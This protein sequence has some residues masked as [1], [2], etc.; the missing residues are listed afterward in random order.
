[1]VGSKTITTKLTSKSLKKKNVE[2]FFDKYFFEIDSSL[3]KALRRKR[4]SL[5]K[6][7]KRNVTQRQNTCSARSLRSD[8]VRAKV[9]S[10]RSDRT[11]IP[12]G[13]YVATELEPKFRSYVVT[14]RSIATTLVHAFL[15]TLRCYLPKTV[16]N[17]F[18]D[19][20]PF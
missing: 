4:E 12:L 19:S 18:H 17:P 13:R 2:T 6:S 9:R 14:G 10:L 3:Q 8:R 7:P 11:S 20:P 5:D 1:M 16:A 15:S